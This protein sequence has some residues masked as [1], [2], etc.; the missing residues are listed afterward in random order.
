MLRQFTAAHLSLGR[1]A[2]N[3]GDPESA[4]RHFT[5]AMATPE[6]L[7]E[8]YHLLQATADVNYWIGKAMNAL[9][10]MEEARNH[11]G[12]SASEAGDFSESAVTAHSPL[13]YFRG[14]SLRE[15]G[16]D[17]EAATLFRSLL[18]FAKNKLK[19]P[20]KV[21]YFATSLPDLLVFDEDPQSRRDAENHLLLALAHHGLGEAIAAGLALRTTYQFTR[22]DLRAADLAREFVYETTS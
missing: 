7:G 13:S 17:E 18:R 14:L 9:G 22:A 5:G 20:A 2:L 3:A 11:F 8:A 19:E 12:L 21:D 4:L 16:R 6:S 10:R 15:L 1:Q